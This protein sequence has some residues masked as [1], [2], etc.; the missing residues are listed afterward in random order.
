MGGPNNTYQ[1]QA[2]ETDLEGWTL[3]ILVL[4]NV[5]ADT[6][7]MYTCVVSNLAGSHNA[8]TF[9]FVDPYFVSP[10]GDVQVSVG[11]RVVLICGAE[12]FPNPEYLWQRVDGMQIRNYIVNGRNF[13]IPSSE[14]GDEGDYYCIASGTEMSFQSESGRITGTVYIP[15]LVVHLLQ[16]AGSHK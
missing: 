15:N 6:G 13:T 9:L 5:T 4:P 14:F 7:G 2:N 8:S 1:W 10:P 3:P 16:T 12:A 11:N